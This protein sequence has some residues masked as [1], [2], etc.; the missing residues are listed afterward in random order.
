MTKT[1]TNAADR[2]TPIL[3]GDTY[4]S[5]ACGGGCT[6]SAHDKALADAAALAERLGAG[7]TPHVWENL[8]WHWDVRKGVATIRPVGDAYRVT[9]DVAPRVD[10]EAETPEDAVGFAT[11]EARTNLERLKAALDDLLD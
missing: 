2:W 6:K 11:Q 9:L 5:P 4:C 8:G 1:L 10:V 7:W 3:R